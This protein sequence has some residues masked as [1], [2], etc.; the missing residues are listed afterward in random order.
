MAIDLAFAAVQSVVSD[1]RNN[2]NNIRSEEDA[3]LQIIT[4]MLTEVLAWSHSDI[5]SES[6]NENGFSDYVIS[7]RGQNAFVIEAKKVG[8]IDLDTSTTRKSTYKISGP[9][10]RRAIIGIKQAAS[11]CHP[12]GIQLAVLTDGVKRIIFLPWVRQASYLEKQAIVFPS[13]DALMDDFSSFYELLSRE[14]IR[15]HTFTVIFDAIHESRLV[16]D[17][18]LTAPIAPRDNSIIQK[19]GLAFDL[20]NVFATFF[21]GLIGDD[22][23]DMLINCFVETQES[24][25]A[26]FSLEKITKNVLGNINPQEGE[27]EDSLRT[28][29]QNTVAGELGQ[30]IFIVGPS[31]AGKSTFLTRFFAKTLAPNIREQCVVISI[32]ALDASGN[33]D[34]ALPWMTERAIDAIYKQTFA[35]GY[36]EWNDLQALYQREYV[37][38]SEGVDAP[39]YR[40]SKDEF[41]EKFAGFVE[42]LVEKDREG[43]L[44]RLLRDVVR[45]RKKLPIFVIDNTDE[46]SIAYKTTIFQYFQALRR[47]TEHCLLIFP[48]TDRSAW[49]FSKTDIFNIYSSRSFF[50]PTPSPREVFRKRIEYLKTKLHPPAGDARQAEYLVGRGIRVTIKDLAAFASVVESIF[51]DQD[52]AAK[53]VGEIANY[54][55]RK[56]LS[57]SRRIVT[58]SVLRVDDLIKAY[59]TGRPITTTPEVFTNALVRGDYQFFRPGDE[60]LLFPMFQVDSTVRQSP[61]VHVR[62]LL[63][64]R[65]TTKLQPAIARATF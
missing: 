46:F 54:N 21:S 50:L 53:R 61:L 40:R 26:D 28:I 25:V 22:D 51:V 56:T 36:P 7:D 42:Q 16:L 43:Y 2:I 23:P 45:N 15:K 52:Y 35:S 3:K 37:K 63:L 60:P 10:L 6:H 18:T 29:V 12:L 32:D 34:A 5:S 47:S 55:I 38:R 59:I 19:T 11:Y 58:S 62:L 14:H 31:G 57:L 9:V 20:E 33:Q 49:V 48:A 41:K 4:R 13:F 65:A 64:L 44:N 27:I 17:R 39:L 1:A 30:T 24:R 8:E